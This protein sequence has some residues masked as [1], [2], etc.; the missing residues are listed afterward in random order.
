MKSEATSVRAEVTNSTPEPTRGSEELQPE[1]NSVRAQLENAATD[2]TA[3]QK[4]IST[5]GMR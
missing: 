2:S 4:L 1:F 3:Q 5:E